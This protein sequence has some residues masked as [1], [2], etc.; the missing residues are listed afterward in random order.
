MKDNTYN[1]WANRSTWLINVWFEPTT[2]DLDW[3]RESLEDRVNELANS[4]NGL[5]KFLADH[6]NLAEIDWSELR[7]S[8][9]DPEPDEECTEA[10][11]EAE[12]FA[13]T[14]ECEEGSDHY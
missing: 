1:G 7:K 8:I 6:I 10:E 11:D 4:D 14:E 3:I 12:K 2:A 9:D 13:H 5:D